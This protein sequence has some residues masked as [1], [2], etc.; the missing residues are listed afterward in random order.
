MMT[1]NENKKLSRNR[2]R[3]IQLKNKIDENMK[4]LLNEINTEKKKKNLDKVKQLEILL[5]KT[6]YAND[7][8]TLQN[9]L[10][11]LNKIYVVNKDLHEIKQEILEDYE[12]VFEMVGNLKVGDQIHQTHT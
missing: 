12:G 4:L 11:E 6:K 5:V 10:E 2:K 9:A 1:I 3:R 7:P 8:N